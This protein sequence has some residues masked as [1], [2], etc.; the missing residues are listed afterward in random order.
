[1]DSHEPK[2]YF[3]FSRCRV[4]GEA[5]G[6]REFGITNDGVAFTF[7]DGLYHYYA[8]HGVMPSDEIYGFIMKLDY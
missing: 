4:C 1:M 3:G 7:P 5:N 8:E 6:S 2:A